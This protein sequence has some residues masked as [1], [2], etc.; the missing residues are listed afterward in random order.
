MLSVYY[1]K[2]T[3]PNGRKTHL[4]RRNYRELADECLM[5]RCGPGGNVWTLK[6]YC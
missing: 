6:G 5:P 3:C 4:P 1:P 2:L